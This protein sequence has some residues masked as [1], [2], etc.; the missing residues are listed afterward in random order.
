MSNELRSPLMRLEDN[1]PDT[2]KVLRW[3]IG[4]LLGGHL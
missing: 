4:A 2:A 3:D 1:D